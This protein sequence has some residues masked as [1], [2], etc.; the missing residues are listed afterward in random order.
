[1]DRVI[2]A[3]A[4]GLVANRFGLSRTAFAAIVFFAEVLT[5]VAVAVATGVGYHLQVYGATWASDQ[6][7]AVGGLT[8]LAFCLPFLLQDEYCVESVL[9]GRRTNGR[10]FL[11]WSLAF[12]A[13]AVIGFL[14]KTTA[15]FSRGWLILFYFSGLMTMIALNAAV[16]RAIGTLIERRLIRPRRLMLVGTPEELTR[17]ETEI[18]DGAA[19]AQ[20][21]ARL[22]VT[23]EL[24]D[25]QQL[26]GGLDAAMARARAL[27]IED[28]I[29][30][31]A[32]YRGDFIE[33]TIAA[34]SLLPV[35]IHLGAGGLVQRFKHARVARF[36]RTM[37]LSLTREPIGPVPALAKR[38]LDLLL[39]TL[40]VI[41]L[42][43][44]LAVVALLIKLDT[45]GP[46]FFRQRRRGYNLV[47]FRMWKFRTM[48]TLD[49]GDV[50]QQAKQGD[51]RVTRVGRILRKYSIDELP[52]LFN[53]IAGNMSLVGPRPHAVAHDRFFEKRIQMY[54]RRLN[55]KPGI[56]GWA[57]VNGFRGATETD[58][59]MQ[60]RVEH[61]LYY[62]DNW[63]LMLDLYI[64]V[65]TVV[66]PRTMRNA[67]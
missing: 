27:G 49:D 59:A 56:T 54:P 62:I 44:V 50:V 64:I 57:Q 32:S 25:E 35:V 33:K 7:A 12:G 4:E 8:A 65:L 28:V 18:A 47:E 46:V 30:S 20:I 39:A 29:I 40:A 67:Y 14:T 58:Y 37:T 61:D 10:L 45:K 60:Q 34:F 9:E 41:F 53:V 5:I 19:G 55:V 43:P 23:D 42:A 31:S 2:E 52:Q 26:D 6:Y 11:V 51:A 63:S 36:G 66:S 13:L 1:M 3:K 21:V 17:M 15:I 48:S 38:S 16:H 24:L 22:P